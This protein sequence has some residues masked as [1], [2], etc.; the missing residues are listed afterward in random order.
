MA[1]FLSEYNRVLP[2]LNS[3]GQIFHWKRADWFPGEGGE[4]ESLKTLQPHFSPI[5]SLWCQQVEIHWSYSEKVS[6]I[7][8]EVFTL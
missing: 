3:W 8:S 1:E 2:L 7:D 5:Q 4:G 6:S